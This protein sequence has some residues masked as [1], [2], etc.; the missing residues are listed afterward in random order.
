MRR[1]TLAGSIG[2]LWRYNLEHPEKNLLSVDVMYQGSVEGMSGLTGAFTQAL[3]APQ[4][5]RNDYGVGWIPQGVMLSFPAHSRPVELRS[6]TPFS[7]FRWYNK[8]S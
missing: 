1:V 4:S 5:V 7:P 3:V 6:R 8:A 2:D